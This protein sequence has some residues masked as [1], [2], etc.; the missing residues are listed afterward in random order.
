M[1]HLGLES[2]LEDP[3]EPSRGV[4][5]GVVFLGDSVVL[6]GSLGNPVPIRVPNTL[7]AGP[8]LVIELTCLGGRIASFL[9][10]RESCGGIAAFPRQNC[11]GGPL[12][13]GELLPSLEGRCAIAWELLSSWEGS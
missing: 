12:A 10:R 6:L 4:I 9:S 1:T 11:L 5:S 7:P 13:K 3:W 8:I 2:S